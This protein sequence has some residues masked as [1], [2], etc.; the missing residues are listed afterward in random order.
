MKTQRIEIVNGGKRAVFLNDG[1][2]WRP[3]WFY[4]DDRPML[5]FKDHEWMS[6]GHVR[7]LHAAQATPEDGG[8][9]RFAGC[10]AYG[11]TPVNWTVDVGPDPDGA[12]FL[13]EC[14]FTPDASIELLEAYTSFETPYSNDV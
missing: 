14:R 1:E 9:Y 7:P 10:I 4:E 12:G 5:R 3:D 8:R 6:L 13:V 2:G 11:A